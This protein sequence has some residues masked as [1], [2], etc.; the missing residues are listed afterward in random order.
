MINRFVEIIDRIKTLKGLHTDTSVAEALKLSKSNFSAYK[1][2]GRIPYRA[3]LRYAN[4]E[5][6]ALDYLLE[7]VPAAGMDAKNLQLV[8]EGKNSVYESRW[9]VDKLVDEVKK[10]LAGENRAAAE[11]LEAVI[12]FHSQSREHEKR[13][14][15]LEKELQA[16]TLEILKA[17][18]KRSGKR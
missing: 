3:L 14:A 15:Q 16:A 5:E 11:S 9:S 6:I 2:K 12:K 8:S 10:I 7:G 4:E 18:Q 17:K 1:Q 13:L